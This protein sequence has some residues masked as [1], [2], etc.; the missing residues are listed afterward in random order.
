MQKLVK[1]AFLNNY[2]RLSR[3]V[4]AVIGIVIGI[5]ALILLVSVV[6]GMYKNMSETISKMQGLMVYSADLYSPVFGTTKSS[7]ENKLS[8]ITGVKKVIPELIHIIGTIDSKKLDFGGPGN[9]Y[10]MIGVKPSDFPESTYGQ[11]SDKIVKGSKLDNSDIGYVLISEKMAEDY[12]KSIGSRIKLDD[13]TLRIKGIFQSDSSFADK[14]FITTIDDV[15]K[16]YSIPSDEVGYFTVIP[17]NPADAKK[18]KDIIE[19]RFNNLQARASQELIEQIG[20]ILNNLKLL[21]ILVSIIAAIVSGIGVINTMLMSVMERTKEIGTLKAVG[22]T[23]ENVIV[24]IVLE[25]TFIGILGGIIGLILGY[26]GS[27]YLVTFVDFP[28]YITFGTAI[29]SF[30]FAFFIGIVGGIYPAWIASKMDPVE[31]LRAD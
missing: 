30:L 26:L 11:M 29:K 14:G 7:Y 1:L 31:S 16:A 17:Q 20:G 19:F 6:D 4:L 22:W 21:V 8:S 25:S 10:V 24:L 27:Y 2:R 12:K 28:S 3:T 13:K 18:I 5:T 9:S 23:K 15:R